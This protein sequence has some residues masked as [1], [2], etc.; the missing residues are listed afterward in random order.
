MRHNKGRGSLHMSGCG[1]TL[2]AADSPDSEQMNLSLF[3]EEHCFPS[4]P[5]PCSAPPFLPRSISRWAVGR[6]WSMVTMV[7]AS[8]RCSADPC[9]W[10]IVMDRKNMATVWCYGL[11]F[12]RWSHTMQSL[13][14]GRFSILILSFILVA[15]WQS[16]R[17]R[18]KAHKSSK[19]ESVCVC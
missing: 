17:L 16:A 12:S 18:L 15:A 3:P 11:I 8:G 19:R 6:K 9:R 14:I 1:D 5:L 4:L 7:T 2:C 13:H 10:S